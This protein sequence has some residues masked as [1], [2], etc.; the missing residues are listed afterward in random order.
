MIYVDTSVIVKLY[1]R[2]DHSREVSAWLKANDEAIPLSPLH[3][4]EFTNAI[5]LK[6]FRKE[7]AEGAAEKALKTFNEHERRGVFYRPQVDWAD[8]FARALNLSKDQTERMGSRA[9]DIIHVALSLAIGADRVFTFDEKQSQLASAAG[10][11]LV[12]M[13]EPE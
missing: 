5:N 6:R 13:Q 3:E 12:H 2:E 4:L 9:L 10:L 11:Q 8:V 7:M 1:V